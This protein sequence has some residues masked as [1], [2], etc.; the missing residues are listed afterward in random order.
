MRR[1]KTFPSSRGRP[2]RDVEPRRRYVSHDTLS[3]FE[4]PTS[5]SPFRHRP[6]TRRHLSTSSILRRWLAPLRRNPETTCFNVRLYAFFRYTLTESV[7]GFE[8]ETRFHS[9]EDANFGETTSFRRSSSSSSVCVR[10]VGGFVSRRNTLS[11]V[12]R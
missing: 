5:N 7:P 11:L 8:E 3:S 10:I 4:R 6:S 9:R 2:E 1:R 12:L